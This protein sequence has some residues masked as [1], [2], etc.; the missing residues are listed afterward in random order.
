MTRQIR[1]LGVSLMVCFAVLFVQLNRLTVFE[2]DELNANPNNT[3]EILRDFTHPRGS[4]T[5]ADGVVKVL[6]PEGR[7]TGR[8]AVANCVALLLVSLVP[9]L[10]GM[11]GRLYL[12]GAALLGLAYLAAAVAAAVRRT[13]ASARLLF[14]TSVLYLAGL[15][16]LLIVDRSGLP[17]TSA[18]HLR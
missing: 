7:M 16:T 3:R 8:Q 11:T 14:F 12:L 18:A 15:C 9:G 5:T 10:A 1:L 6:D 17:L 2:A 13:P 4:V